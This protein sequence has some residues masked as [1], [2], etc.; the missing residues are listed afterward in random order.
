MGPKVQ[1]I[2]GH[3]GKHLSTS[4]QLIAISTVLLYHQILKE[5]KGSQTN[6]LKNK[7]NPASE[8]H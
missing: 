6:V 2:Y 4:I 8:Y 5:K 1:Y 3:Q 7:Q